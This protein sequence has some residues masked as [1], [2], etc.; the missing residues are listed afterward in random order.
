MKYQESSKFKLQTS[1]VSF[2]QHNSSPFELI[3]LLIS[4]TS[5]SFQSGWSTHRLCQAT[6]TTPIG[7]RQHF[8]MQMGHILKESS[9]P[10][11]LLAPAHATIALTACTVPPHKFCS[12][13]SQPSMCKFSWFYFG[14][15]EGLFVPLFQFHW[16]YHFPLLASMG[17]IILLS[18]LQNS[19]HCYLH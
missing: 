13:S 15:T 11:T 18:L 10:A 6:G 17:C 7:Q 14:L 9:S 3:K 5:A 12:Q 4:R 8:L 1:V 2:L 19:K 16:N